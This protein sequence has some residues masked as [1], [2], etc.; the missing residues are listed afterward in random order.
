[1]GEVGGIVAIIYAILIARSWVHQ[2]T[3]FS[4][5][6]FNALIASRP[7]VVETRFHLLRDCNVIYQIP[8]KTAALFKRFSARSYL[9]CAA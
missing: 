7:D 1:V 4:I 3:C 5:W 6:L 2:N 8:A 9:I